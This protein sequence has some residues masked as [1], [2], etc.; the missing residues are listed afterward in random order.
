ML[1]LTPAR[2]T[3]VKAAVVGQRRGSDEAGTVRVERRGCAGFNT[4]TM[5][6]PTQGTT[7]AATARA[8]ATGRQTCAMQRRAMP[9]A[10]TVTATALTTAATEARLD[11]CPWVAAERASIPTASVVA[12]PSTPT[13]IATASD[14]VALLCVFRPADATD[15]RV[16][17]HAPG[18]QP[19]GRRGPS[20]RRSFSF[21]PRCHGFPAPESPGCPTHCSLMISPAREKS[22][23]RVSGPGNHDP[24]RRNRRR[25]VRLRADH[26]RFVRDRSLR[27]CE[28]TTDP[29]HPSA[30]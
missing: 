10:A 24:R 2:T 25:S 11:A 15:A 16:A 12:T 9:T 4:G 28:V 22:S 3:T 23:R 26:P 29:G 6:K 19:F 5:E 13:S 17:D 7:T 30:Q 21:D 8:N 20:R 14:W 27:R 1:G 18:S